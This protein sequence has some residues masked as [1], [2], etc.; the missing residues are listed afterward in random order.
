MSGATVVIHV[1][2]WF[3][4]ELVNAQIALFSMPHIVV[5]AVGP[6]LDGSAGGLPCPRRR[7]KE[8]P[9]HRALFHTPAT[10][11]RFDSL[12]GGLS[13]GAQEDFAGRFVALGL[14]RDL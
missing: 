8:K 13:A 7:F 11:A 12:A 2:S 4:A 10:Q 9:S 14:I 5:V 6:S 1:W 3:R